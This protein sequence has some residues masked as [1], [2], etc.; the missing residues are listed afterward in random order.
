[1]SVNRVAMKRVFSSPNLIEVAQFKEA[2]EEA[3]IACFVRNENSI[4][5]VGGIPVT[6]GTPEVWIE[7]DSKFGVA[8]QVKQEWLTQA[9]APGS[10]WTCPACGERSEPQFASCWK[11]GATKP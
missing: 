10:E 3:G 11:C 5:L 7:D 1:M 8:L 2:L 6:D 4:G 9:P